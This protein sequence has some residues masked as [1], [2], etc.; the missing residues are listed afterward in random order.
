MNMEDMHES[1]YKFI[2]AVGTSDVS[3]EDAGSL[4]SYAVAWGAEVAVQARNS[5]SWQP[6]LSV[7]G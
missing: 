3:W 5:D 7:S 2:E 6:R 4:P 1:V